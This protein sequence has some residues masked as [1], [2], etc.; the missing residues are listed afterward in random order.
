VDPRAGLDDVEKR[1]FLTLPGLELRSLGRP[2]RK[3]SL[4]PLRYPGS[5][6]LP[7]I[8]ASGISDI[9]S[10]WGR[11]SCEIG[12]R[13]AAFTVSVKPENMWAI[14]VRGAS[15]RSDTDNELR[16]FLSC[17]GDRNVGLEQ[18]KRQISVLKFPAVG[19]L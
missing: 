9:N 16:R 10:V 8:G 17:V 1:K 7:R 19:D 14:E 13:E 3:Q 18:Q 4:Y 2:A 6:L 15:N 5:L 12:S 11:S